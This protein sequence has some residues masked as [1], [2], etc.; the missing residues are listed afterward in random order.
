MP[1]VKTSIKV[2][3]STDT[4]GKIMPLGVKCRGNCRKIHEDITKNCPGCKTYMREYGRKN[5]N[6]KSKRAAERYLSDSERIKEKSNKRY[7]EKKDTILE[8]MKEYRERRC[9]YIRDRE[10]SKANTREGKYLKIIANAEERKRIVEMTKD[11]IMNM[12]DL[13]CVYCGKETIDGVKRNGID[14]M[15]NS[16][17][18]TLSNCAPCCEICNYMKQSLDPHT[19]VERCAQISTGHDGIGLV[20][21]YWVDTNFMSFAKYKA[22]VIREGGSFELTKEEYEYLRQQTCIYCRRPTTETHHNGIDRI[23]SSIGYIRSNCVTC[24]GGCNIAK[25][26]KTPGEFIDQCKII[27]GRKHDFPEMPRYIYI[28]GRV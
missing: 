5:K 9:D 3:W 14:R 20:T 28:W 25:G 21:E 13:P 26:K 27:A 1:K 19:F 22:K 8:Q 17:G 6:K 23:D 18:Y 4:I 10:T 11:E 2:I 7:Q 16:V 12:T 15:D 24:C